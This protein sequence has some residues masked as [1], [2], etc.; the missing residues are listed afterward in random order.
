M[1]CD[2]WSPARSCARV[3]RRETVFSME[4][5]GMRTCWAICCRSPSSISPSWKRNSPS[6]ISTSEFSALSLGFGWYIPP[7]ES[8]SWKGFSFRQWLVFYHN[9]CRPCSHWVN[10]WF[11]HWTVIV[12]EPG[13]LLSIPSAWHTVMLF[14]HFVTGQQTSCYRNSVPSKKGSSWYSKKHTLLWSGYKHVGLRK[15]LC[16]FA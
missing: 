9:S 7:S 11:S 3:I 1:I 5:Q 4:K 12:R 15:K 14:V 2:I 13:L 8:C 6:S 10:V 16:D